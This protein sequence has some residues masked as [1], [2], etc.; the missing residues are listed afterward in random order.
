M[1]KFNMFA[2]IA[3][4]L[5]AVGN[6]GATGGT[7][8]GALPSS[9]PTPIVN[10]SGALKALKIASRPTSNN[11]VSNALSKTNALAVSAMGALT[12]NTKAGTKAKFDSTAFQQG[13]QVTNEQT[14]QVSGGMNQMGQNVA[15]SN[16]VTTNMLTGANLRNIKAVVDTQPNPTSA[17]STLTSN[18]KNTGNVSF[19][20]SSIA[21]PG[22]PSV[23]NSNGQAGEP[24]V[25]PSAGTAQATVVSAKDGAFGNVT[26]KIGLMTQGSS[27]SMGGSIG[28]TNNLNLMGNFGSNS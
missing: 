26:S 1:K 21:K 22:A 8:F 4:S 19:I 6:V 28:S 18:T 5:A 16:N 2:L 13:A 14:S 17:M 24:G 20:N 9:F 25:L 15:A 27:N 23:G 12:A 7:Q 11:L 10:R 3:L